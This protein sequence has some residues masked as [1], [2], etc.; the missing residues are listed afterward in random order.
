MDY[1]EQYD[2]NQSSSFPEFDW[3]NE[4]IAA[5]YKVPAHNTMSIIKAKSAYPILAVPTSRSY[6]NLLLKYTITYSTDEA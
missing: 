4:I 6:D 3:T 2:Y 5:D 1:S